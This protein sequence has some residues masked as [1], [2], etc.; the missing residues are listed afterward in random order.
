MA[1]RGRIGAVRAG[2]F[3][4]GAHLR[5]A[6]FG[7]VDVGAHCQHRAGRDQLEEVDAV[8]EQHLGL[9]ARF[10]GRRGHPEPHVGRQL[11]VGDHAVEFA[12]AAG[13]GEVA[14]G[15]EHPRPG[16]AAGVD[17][18]AQRNVG[19]PTVGADVANGG[20]PGHQRRPRVLRADQRGRL[21]RGLERQCEVGV[22]TR[23]GEVR[24][25]VDQAGKDRVTR[26]VD[27]LGAVRR[28]PTRFYPRD[29]LV[30]RQ[31]AAAGG[32]FAGPYVEQPA[33]LDV[34]RAGLRG[35]R[36]QRERGAN[37]GRSGPQPASHL[38]FASRTNSAISGGT[39]TIDSTTLASACPSRSEPIGNSP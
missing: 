14:A 20:E 29:P 34:E 31:D 26:P 33:G 28:R 9:L 23:I 37:D 5:L 32:E 15:D 21:R 8:G 24:V 36:R 3:D 6:Q 18:I 4:R 22:L 7:L 11:V 30:L 27:P 12:P 19:Q 2:D 39:S 38:L 25:Q 17:G 13:R 10:L 35:G 16:H 1:V